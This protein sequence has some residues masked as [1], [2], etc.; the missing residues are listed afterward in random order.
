MSTEA[1]RTDDDLH[2]A[3][4]R[5]AAE[6]PGY[7]QPVAYGVA[8]L[9]GTTLT[10][11]HVNRPGGDH[12]LPAVVL[13]TVCGHAAATATYRLEPAQLATAIE[14]LAPAEAAAH[15][16]HPNLWSWRALAQ[17]SPPDSE[18]V[19]FFVRDIDDPIVDE[20]DAAFRARLRSS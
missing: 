13:A 11:A 2:A 15:W 16:D 14:L 10:F 20:W 17:T 5:F 9:D 6:I 1:W 3:R 8:R 4:Q 19:A 7:A 18:Y 12:L